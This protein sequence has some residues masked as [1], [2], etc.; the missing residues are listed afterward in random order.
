M[1]ARFMSK[2]TSEQVSTIKRRILAI[3]GKI[4]S[5]CPIPYKQRW[6]TWML[7][8]HDAFG[9]Q[10]KRK[11]FELNETKF[12][13]CHI[14]AGMTL[15]DVGAYSGYYTLLFSRLTGPT[16]NVFAFEPSNREYK[17][18]MRHIRFNRCTNVTT[19]NKALNNHN[20]NSNFFIIK[21][22][23]KGMNSL[24]PP[25]DQYQ[26]TCVNV[27]SITLDQFLDDN[28]I[29]ETHFIKVDIEGAELAFFQGASKIFNSISPP[30]IM[31]ECSDMRTNLWDYKASDIIQFLTE[32]D[33]SCFS[34]I[35]NGDLQSCTSKQ[36]YN[37]N[38]V[39]IH[40]CKL[41]S[42]A[43]HIHD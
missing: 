17:R 27:E 4:I 1:L 31:F 12:F 29:V 35:D 37:E 26:Y 18:L 16:G 32:K 23:E 10:L 30:T 8:G 42:F 14:K 38:I 9:Q 41:E 20:E 13:E 21:G 36:S 19:V 33:Y 6:G 40:K 43:N 39:A 3:F 5:Y 24:M 7:A 28:N 22:V 2:S 15:L 34:I 25:F 11:C